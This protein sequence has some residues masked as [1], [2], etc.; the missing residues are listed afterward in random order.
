MSNILTVSPSP[1]IHSGESVNKIMYRVILAMM[2]AL[3][4]SVFVFG[5]DAL[6]VTLIAV[7]AC[8]AFEYLIQKYLMKVVPSI[9]DGSAIIT[10]I[11]L[12]F[13]VP[14][15]L[16]WWIIIIGA[17]VSIGIGKISFG[18]IGN[19]I[20]NPALVGRVF[21]LISFP[22][23]MTS[24]PVIKQAGVDAVTSA[25]PLA[26]IKESIKNSQPISDTLG[27]LPGTM[28][29]LLGNMGGSLGEVSA[30]LL[31][32]GGIYMLFR[33]VITWH[34]PV[35]VLGSIALFSGILW[36]VDPDLY[37]NP[38]FHILTGGAMLG[39]IFMATDM[40]TSPMTGKGQIIYGIGIGLITISIRTWG[41]YPEGISFA[42]LL[43]NAVVPI[44]NTYVKPKRFGGQK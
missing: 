27:N 20:F 6:K 42:I 32:L 23:Q 35:A 28:D 17:L 3:A 39:A 8:V 29:L 15:G 44:I 37:I 22:V 36:I 9:T 1:H 25:T 10:G 5:I 19:N 12:A 11:L 33:K 43:M 16:P 13:N 14:S 2:P 26:L 30:I 7:A 34:I 31:I 40:V 38:V 24:W 21:L 18:G 4:W 41:A